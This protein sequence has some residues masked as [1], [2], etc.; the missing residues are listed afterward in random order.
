[1][2]G[3]VLISRKRLI[4]LENIELRY[5]TMED[6]VKFAQERSQELVIRNLEY[7]KSIHRLS[8]EL[9]DLRNQI[10]SISNTKAKSRSI[11][12]LAAYTGQ[13]TNAV[14]TKL[15]ELRFG[16][17]ETKIKKEDLIEIESEIRRTINNI[18]FI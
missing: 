6:A 2:K 12:Y 8:L 11:N 4:E 3:K 5:K 13:I 10:E 18:F 7:T 17:F 9:K 14:M 1:M 16:F 15:S